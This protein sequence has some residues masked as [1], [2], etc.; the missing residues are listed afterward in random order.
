MTNDG[1]YG[2]FSGLPA[3]ARHCN[4]SFRHWTCAGRRISIEKVMKPSRLYAGLAIAG[5]L[6]FIAC[7][8]LPLFGIESIPVFGRLDELASAYG[9]AIVCFLAGAHWGNYLLARD[10]TPLNLFVTSNVIFLFA[11][12]AYV[13]AS[14]ASAIIAQLV[15]LL[16]LLAIDHRLKA[17]GIVS[18][19]YLSVRVVA[20][21]I[22]AVSLLTILLT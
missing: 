4:K 18:G 6:P 7:A 16:A 8:L 12:F 19:D 3:Q 22:A 21:T 5:T 11:W 13:G 2:A 1:V 14:L 17:A 9:L 20:T 10:G 15:A